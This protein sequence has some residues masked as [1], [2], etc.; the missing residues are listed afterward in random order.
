MQN[1]LSSSTDNRQIIFD[2]DGTLAAGKQAIDAEMAR[3]P[4]FEVHMGGRP[5]SISL[6]QASTRPMESPI[7]PRRPEWA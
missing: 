2:L 5:R 6:A 1:I 3:L 4:D 7:W